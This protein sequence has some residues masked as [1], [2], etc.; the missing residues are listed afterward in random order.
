M[1]E[2]TRPVI[3]SEP[4]TKATAGLTFLYEIVC[5]DAQGDELSLSLEESHS[6]GGELADNGDGTGGRARQSAA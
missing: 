4:G 6:C 5:T 3:S 2:D 1:P